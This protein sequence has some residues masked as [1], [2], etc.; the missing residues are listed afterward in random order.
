[1]KTFFLFS[2]LVIASNLCFSQY[3]VSLYGT[4]TNP[5]GEYVY[6]KY[7]KDFISYEEV[8]VDSAKLEKNGKFH[9]N[10]SW[11]LPAAATFAHGD[12]ITQMFLTPGDSMSVSLDTKEF[13]ETVKYTGRGAFINTYLAAKT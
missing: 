5:K 11:P 10:F 7:Y 13:D 4:I 9:M 6:V 12:E 1:M 8:I 3:K 2:Y